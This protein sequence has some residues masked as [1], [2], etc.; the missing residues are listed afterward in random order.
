MLKFAL[1]A[2][3]GAVG[4][5]ARYL[6]QGWVQ[7]STR[8]TFPL[9]TLIVNVSGCFAIGLLNTLF[10]GPWPIRADYRIGLVVGVL[11]GFTTFSAFGWESF[12]LANGGELLRASLNVLLSVALGLAAVFAG[13]RLAQRWF[14]VS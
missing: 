8:G 6:L 9:G 1:I 11:G 3:G 12:S 7:E 2:L 4:S 5:L 13:A 14:G 10:T